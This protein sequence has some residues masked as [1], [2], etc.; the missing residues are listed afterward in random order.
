MTELNRTI[1]G[2]DVKGSYEIKNSGTVN[3]DIREP[4][5][6]RDFVNPKENFDIDKYLTELFHLVKTVRTHKVP[7]EKLYNGYSDFDSLLSIQYYKRV[8]Y[9]ETEREA[10]IAD[11]CSQL[12]KEFFRLYRKYIVPE[13]KLAYQFVLPVPK[14]IKQILKIV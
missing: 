6:I 1:D 10:Y 11:M 3:I 13:V 4:F 2:I 9:S 8:F 7:F 5:T 14:L 12:G